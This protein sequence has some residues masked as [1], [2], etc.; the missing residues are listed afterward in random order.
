ML[1]T[2]KIWSGTFTSSSVPVV[3]GTVEF[4]VKPENS[5]STVL[6]LKYTGV[7]KMGATYQIIAQVDGDSVTCHLDNQQIIFT[8]SSRSDVEIRGTYRSTNPTDAGTLVCQPGKLPPD[9]GLCI[10]C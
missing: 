1:S 2:G 7:Y 4:E 3:F 10:I 6:N 8:I 9:T 5:Y